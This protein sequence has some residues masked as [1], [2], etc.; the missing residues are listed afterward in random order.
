M[1]QYI[2]TE[3]SVTPDIGVLQT[4]EMQAVLDLCRD[5]GGYVIVPR[6][7]YRVAGLYLHS[8]TT[9]YLEAGAR[10][11]GSDECSDYRV[12]PFPEG[13]Q[14]RSD[15][16]MIRAYYGK[17]WEEYRRAIIT[18]YCEHNLTIIGE[19]DSV[20][21]GPNCYDPD[22]EEGYRGPHGIYF[23]NCEN[24]HLHGYTIQHTGNF[25]HQLDLCKNTTVTNVTC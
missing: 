5:G 21:D 1:K 15:M 18:S 12:F 3:Y 17:P 22:G 25:M 11:I 24:I 9:L 7:T 6:G 10:L 14:D 4:D 16:E 23:S 20:I 8:D 2:I 13:M 19:E